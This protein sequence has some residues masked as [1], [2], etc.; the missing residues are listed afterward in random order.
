MKI[1][2][3]TNLALFLTGLT[4]VILKLCSVIT[5]PWAVVLIPWYPMMVGLAVTV[6]MSMVVLTALLWVFMI[7]V[8]QMMVD[9]L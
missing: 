3:S 1:S 9:E 7:A 6:A 2:I 5:W 8:I 4:F